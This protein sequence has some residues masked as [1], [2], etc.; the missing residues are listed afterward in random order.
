MIPNRRARCAFTLLELLVVIAIIALLASLALPVTE[1]VLAKARS[2]Q[3]SSNLRQVGVAVLAWATDHDNYFPRI[4]TDPQGQV[5]VYD[6]DE[7]VAGLVETLRGYGLDARFVQCPTDLKTTRY[8][9]TKGSSYEWRPILD[10]EKVSNPKVYGRL[11]GMPV[12]ASRIRICL[13][14]ERIHHGQQNR[15]YADGHV[16]G[17]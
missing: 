11:A 5:Q 4:E 6:A 12:P 3:C 17:F 15:L 8:F 16:R 13:D 1:G 7:K 10:G 14:Y 2:T 9:Q